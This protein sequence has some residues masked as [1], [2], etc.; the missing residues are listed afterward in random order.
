MLHMEVNKMGGN[1]MEYRFK[2]INLD[3]PNCASKIETKINHLPYIDHATLNFNTGILLIQSNQKVEDMLDS[4]TKIVQSI[5]PDV[6]VTMTYQHVK[7]FTV[8]NLDCALCAKKIEDRLKKENYIDNIILNFNTKKLQ[9]TWNNQD[10]PKTIMKK[11]QN[12]INQIEDGVVI[13]E[14]KTSTHKK[15]DF[16][17]ENINL[18]N[19]LVISLVGIINIF[20]K[21]NMMIFLF[22]Y[23]LI[24]GKVIVKAVK[25]ICKGEIFDENFL[26]VVATV[27]AFIIGEYLEAVAVMVFYEIGELFQSY[28]VEKSRKSISSLMD[29]RAS[30]A[31]IIKDNQ[32]EKVDPSTVCIGDIM[33][34]SPGERV[35][36]DGIVIEGRSTLDTSA[37]TGES[38]P[39]EVN[40][41]DEIC[42]GVVNLS[43]V[44]KVRVTKNA[45]E[46]TVSR[47]LDLVEN[48]TNK[49]AP[50]E[51]F[52]TRFAKIYTPIVCFLAIIVAFVPT[53]LFHQPFDVWVYRALTF[54]VV[55]C[56]CALVISVPLTLFAGIGGAS[57]L[58]VLIKGGHDLE[59]L[60]NLKTLVVDKTG[61]L[62][63]GVFSVIKV[64]GENKDQILELAALGESYSH[65]PIARSIVNEYAKTIDQNRVK[66]YEEIAGHGIQAIVDGQQLYLGNEKMMD[67]HH[68]QYISSNHVG[69]TIHVAYNNKYLGYI[70][71]ADTIK[72]TTFLGLKQLK[73]QGID[74]IIMLTGDNLN[75]A[76]DVA[77]KLNIEEYYANLLPQNKVEKVENIL[78][79]SS[80]CLGF[81]GDGINDAPVLARSDIGIAMGGIGSD[82]AIEAA[83]IVL[84]NDDLTTLAKAMQLSCQVNRILHQNIV[85]SLVV[86]ISVLCLVTIGLANMWLGVFADVGVTLIAILNSMRAMQLQGTFQ[87]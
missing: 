66:A 1:K 86:K 35:A 47:I 39:R 74:K 55:S 72:E 3:C 59:R 31:I 20:P 32:E 77:S 50:I 13:E 23:C 34:V 9:V 84:M 6:S 26:M 10:D 19:G 5:E 67:L 75:V 36:L 40:M 48:A 58:G 65:H 49:K 64:E 8:E 52:I 11:I 62:T 69:T 60:K 28:A 18:I 2:L 15:Y 4:I 38:M 53:V 45:S 63:K 16:I 56:P 78:S 76:K 43:G 14:D 81:I 70:V 22:S 79:H 17:K 87:D 12:I 71:V 85:F 30:Y 44:I 57:K 25:N 29:I 51:R 24:G 54:L 61:T 82:V 37:L 21:Y 46:S 42:S 27:G 80:N 7:E 33:V 73:K 68:I 41:N 83:D